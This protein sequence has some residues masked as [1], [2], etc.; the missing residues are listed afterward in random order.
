M[1]ILARLA[2]A[3]LLAAAAEAADRP[4]RGLQ[5]SVADPSP[6]DPARRTLRGHALDRSTAA[7]LVGDPLAQ[8][9]TL[10][11]VAAGAASQEQT[12]LVPPG[13]AQGN[14]PGWRLR[15]SRR[16]PGDIAFVY[17]DEAGTHGPVR[18]LRLGRDRRGLRID[19][20][21]SGAGIMLRPPNPGTRGGFVLAIPGGDTYCVGFGGAAGGRVAANGRRRFRMARAE[22]A[23]CPG[24]EA[25]ASFVTFE[26]E[27]VRPLAASPDRTRL[28]AA[29]TPDGRL[30][31]LAVGPSGDL[32]PAASVPV[33]LEPVAVA[34]RNDREVWVVNHVSDSISIVDVG[35]TPPRVVRTLLTCDEPRDL[36]FAG[37]RA[38]VTT[39][40]RGQTCLDAGGRPIDPKLT[41]PGTSRALVQVFDATTPGDI[42]LAVVE[43]FGDTPRALAVSPDGDTVYAAVF[44][45]GN[46]TTTVHEQAV[47]DGGT[48]AQPCV[49][50]DAVV[51]GGLP[52]PNPLS[53]R[54]EPQPETGLIVRFDPDTA[55]WLDPDGRDW[56]NAVRF[57]LPDLDVFAIDARATPPVERRA[58]AGV[59]TVLFDMTVNPISGALYVSNTEANN[60][61]RFEGDR[62]HSCITSSVRGRLHEAR[63]TVLNGD[64]VAPR[65]LNPHLEPYDVAPAPADRSRSLA[66]PLGMATD[67]TSL[68]VAA[69]GSGV[70]A[71]LDAAALE[72]GVVQPSAGDHVAVSGGGPSGLVLLGTRLYVTTRFDDGIS[73]IDT[74]VRAEIAHLRFHD[75]EPPVVVQGR[76]FLYDAVRTSANGEAS[77]GACHVFG[78][79]DGLAWDLGDPD[80]TTQPNPNPFEL[81]ADDASFRALKGPMATQSL[82]GLA[83]HGPLH[84]RGDRTGGPGGDPLDVAAGFREFNRAFVSLLGRSAPLSD[85]DMQAFADFVL[86]ITYPPNP[87]RSLDGSLTPSQERGRRIYFG[88]ISDG[89]RTCDGCHVLDEGAGFFGSD[90]ES[91][92]DREPQAFKIPHLRNAY[93]K[94]GMFGMPPL[95]TIRPGDN[96]ATGPQVRGFGFGHDASTDTIVRFLSATVFNLSIAQARDVEE[97]LLAF[98]SNLAPIVGQQVTLT[99]DNGASAGP[100]IDLLLA[101]AAAAIPECD[102]V[103]K[104]VL[105]GI[106]RGWMRRATGS[107]RSDRDGEPEVTDATLRAQAAVPGQERTYTC[108]P[109]GSGERAGIDRDQ[110]GCL[111]ADDPKPDDPDVGCGGG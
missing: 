51:P 23:A 25:P 55:A 58:W 106:P 83:H 9:V 24:L 34:A 86:Q 64:M 35:S 57:D 14:G 6:P 43:L 78:D 27:P 94:V 38:F 12:L 110:D 92:F 11:I 65:H 41:T 28:F 82:R 74:G 30:E 91:S 61:T 60:L 40:R 10:R 7:A 15:R 48:A 22:R 72:R 29:N 80:G 1:R 36:V 63:I 45:S 20:R 44:R 79:A 13:A 96:A 42:P 39:A 101:R 68:W 49:V 105:G 73:V 102:V 90:G 103:V 99:A 59:G 87:I 111:D 33:G 100:R 26:S 108:M 97:F 37:D 46:R 8:G 21:L 104:G 56:R 75:P 17:A 76:P 84:W 89:V 70:V 81:A 47:C 85:A 52:F 5:F 3:V 77:C 62:T 54:G 50:G 107:F 109:P 98:E 31:I 16:R 69:F 19:L 67:G 71:V 88:E 66:A 4:V 53:C 2:A 93:Q 18:V 95:A 32:E